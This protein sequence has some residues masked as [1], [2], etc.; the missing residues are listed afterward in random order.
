MEPLEH[1]PAAGL[2]DLAA[3]IADITIFALIGPL[4]LTALALRGGSL[5]WTWGLLTVS[6]LGWLFFDA[7]DSVSH[8]QLLVEMQFKP[9]AECLR[10]LACSFAMVAGIAQRWAISGIAVAGSSREDEVLSSEA[11]E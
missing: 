7:L 2:V 8:A 10:L 11:A 1:G 3:S 5:A 6:S 4:I 9:W